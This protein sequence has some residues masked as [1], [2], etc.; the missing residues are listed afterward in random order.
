MVH[1]HP[2][3]AQC[4]WG[5]GA[6]G[7]PWAIYFERGDDIV[8]HGFHLHPFAAIKERAL[9]FKGR[10]ID[11]DL[12]DNY[13]QNE[14]HLITDADEAAFAEISPPE[15]VF[16][17]RPEPIDVRSIARWARSHATPLHRWLFEQPITIQGSGADIGDR[18]VC[19]AVLNEIANEPKRAMGQR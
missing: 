3:I 17:L 15:R 4:F 16:P 12:A 19:A 11:V 10:T 18:A 5:S 2:A 6:S 8:L 14:I 13:R 1:R 7:T 9:E